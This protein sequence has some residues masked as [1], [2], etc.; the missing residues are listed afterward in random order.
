MVVRKEMV[1]GFAIGHGGIAFSLADSALAFA[2]NS[3][4]QVAV[5]VESTVAFTSPAEVGDRLVAVAT[6]LHRGGQVG[7]Y[8][9]EITRANP[10]DD[11]LLI[12]HLR[13][14]VYV[15]NKPVVSVSQS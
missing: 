9:V 3:Y 7:H 12:G 14:V 2:A 10:R 5:T 6:E 8:Q 1:N 4:G 13:G 11:E 15:T